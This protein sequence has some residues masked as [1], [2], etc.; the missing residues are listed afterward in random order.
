MRQTYTFREHRKMNSKKKKNHKLISESNLSTRVLSRRKG[1]WKDESLLPQATGS[2]IDP[3]KLSSGVNS[4]A[5]R[6]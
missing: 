6:V 1:I 4:P 2:P 5:L 3:F